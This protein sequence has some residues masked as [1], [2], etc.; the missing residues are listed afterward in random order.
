MSSARAV[1]TL[2]GPIAS[3]ALTQSDPA[4]MWRAIPVAYLVGATF[5]VPVLRRHLAPEA[6]LYLVL[7][8]LGLHALDFS[9]VLLQ[10]ACPAPCAGACSPPSRCSTTLAMGTSY[11]VAG[12]RWTTGG[13]RRARWAWA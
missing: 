7:N 6:C 9:M 4:R 3:R 5:G 8:H 13:S 1:G 2:L 11:G 10:A 12:W